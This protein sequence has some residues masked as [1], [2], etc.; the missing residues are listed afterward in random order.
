M[1]NKEK[2][3]ALYKYIAQLCALKYRVVTDVDKQYWTRYLKDIPDAPEYISVFYRDR[4]EEETSDDT[5]LLT[6]KKPDFQRCPEPHDV[7]SEWLEPGWDRFTNEVKIGRMRIANKGKFC[8]NF[9]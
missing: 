2:I 9:I 4:V 5:V 1:K 6:V 8:Y 3:I 7:I